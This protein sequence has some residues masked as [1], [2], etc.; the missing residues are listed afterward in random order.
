[1]VARCCKRGPLDQERHCHATTP[2]TISAQRGA[3]LKRQDQLGQAGKRKHFD[4]SEWKK[5]CSKFTKCGKPNE[6]LSR[7]NQTLLLA[8]ILQTSE[9]LEVSFQLACRSQL[10]NWVLHCRH[11]FTTLPVLFQSKTC[12]SGPT[13]HENLSNYSPGTADRP[14]LQVELASIRKQRTAVVIGH[15]RV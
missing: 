5:K 13:G 11:V 8:F 4:E 12:L 3:E 9:G 6:Q 10:R 2:G 14:S 7:Y 15:K 1:M